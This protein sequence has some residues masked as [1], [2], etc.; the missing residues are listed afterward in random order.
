M[1]TRL[2]EW[3][4]GVMLGKGIH[5]KQI[6][7]PKK[8]TEK[9]TQELE[10]QRKA[11]IQQLAAHKD[12]EARKYAS[13]LYTIQESDRNDKELA[14]RGQANELAEKAHEKGKYDIEKT[15][16]QIMITTDKIQ[17]FQTLQEKMTETNARALM[18]K[19]KHAAAKSS[20]AIIGAERLMLRIMSTEDIEQIKNE[21]KRL[22]KLLTLGNEHIQDTITQTQYLTTRV[23][24][25]LKPLTGSILTLQK[26]QQRTLIAEE[27]L[28]SEIPRLAKESRTTEIH[29]ICAR[30]TSTLLYQISETKKQLQTIKRDNEAQLIK[31]ARQTKAERGIVFL[32]V[33]LSQPIAYTPPLAFLPG[34]ALPAILGIDY[35]LRK[36][37]PL[38]MG[39][40]PEEAKMLEKSARAIA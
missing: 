10:E 9:R 25:E 35:I 26:S 33:A 38:L 34:A 37:I 24:A 40:I 21:T 36:L 28:T 4:K 7:T 3:A 16:N 19:I 18:H 27:N 5:P 20:K 31:L 39:R 15:A 1:I 23:P 8:G 30:T 17:S 29:K 22:Q 12:E 6:F 13:I 11:L 2:K 14:I 32:A